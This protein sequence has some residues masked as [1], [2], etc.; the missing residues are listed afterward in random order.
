MRYASETVVDPMTQFRAIPIEWGLSEEK[1]F[2]FLMWVSFRATFKGWDRCDALQVT[3][4]VREAASRF[5]VSVSTVSGW[6]TAAKKSG[7]LLPTNQSATERGKGEVYNLGGDML[8]TV[9]T[10]EQAPNKP[11]TSS[12]QPSVD[13]VVTC[14]APANNL[15]TSSEQAPNVNK[16]YSP[17]TPKTSSPS[18][19]RSPRKKEEIPPIPDDLLPFLEEL[20]TYW[21]RKSLEKGV[22]RRVTI[23]RPVD[24]WEKIC[25]N[26]G[27]DEPRVCI[28]AGLAYLDLHPTEYVIGMDNFFG[29]D[30]KYTKFVVE[31]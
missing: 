4:T 14:D 17:D 28:N 31:D 21:P 19:A 29:K 12:E 10:T 6:V 30:R 3:F 16:V 26:R 13:S 8:M 20:K 25:K 15:R 7:L 27:A 22:T 18:R 24:S 23:L 5:G 11:R 2:K 9:K 1:Y